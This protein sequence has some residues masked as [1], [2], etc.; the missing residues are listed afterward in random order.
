VP[1]DSP[2]SE[3]NEA[4][5]IALAKANYSPDLKPTELE[6]LRVS[7]RPG[8][9]KVPPGACANARQVRGTFFDGC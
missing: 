5:L 9:A 8:Q 7:M 1:F 3:R 4:K 2:L 6:V